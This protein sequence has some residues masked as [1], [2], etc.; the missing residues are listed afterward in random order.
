MLIL[1]L[2]IVSVDKGV[3][4]SQFPCSVGCVSSESQHRQL[5]VCSFCL[6]YNLSRV[7]LRFL[8]IGLFQYDQ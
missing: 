3:G 8:S 2:I 5:A 4:G 7:C 6:S 1:R